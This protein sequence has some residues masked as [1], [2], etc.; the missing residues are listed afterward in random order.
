[1]LILRPTIALAKSL[2][3]E[4]PTRGEN[5]LSTVAVY[6]WSVRPFKVERTGYLLFTNAASLFCMVV[7]QRGITT[8]GKLRQ[9]FARAVHTCMNSPEEGQHHATVIMA[10]MSACCFDRQNDRAVT[11]SMNELAFQAGLHLRAGDTLHDTISNLNRV[12]MS[13]LGMDYA[14][15]KFAAL[16]PAPRGESVLG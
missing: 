9:A 15:R 14:H 3:I 13:L 10:A 2:K 11:G 5:P 1:M 16:S 12:P 7:P 6:D 8:A 4:L